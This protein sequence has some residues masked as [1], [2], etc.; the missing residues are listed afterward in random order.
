MINFIKSCIF[1][2]KMWGQSLRHFEVLDIESH[3]LPYFKF[4]MLLCF[5]GMFRKF[6]LK[7]P[8]I[9]CWPRHTFLLTL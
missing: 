8:L 9:T 5:V 6:L 1:G 7:H 3:M 4:N 2:G